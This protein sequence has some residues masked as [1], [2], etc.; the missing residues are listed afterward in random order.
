MVGIYRYVL[1]PHLFND[2]GVDIITIGS[3][4][5][6][7]A[8]LNRPT[9]DK[10]KKIER[11]TPIPPTRCHHCITPSPAHQMSPLYSPEPHPPDVTTV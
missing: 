2:A 7:S 4:R 8:L 1:I 5:I 3:E 10:K 6:F 9:A 11:L